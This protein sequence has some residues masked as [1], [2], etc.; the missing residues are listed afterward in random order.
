MCSNKNNPWNGRLN[1]K[2]SLFGDFRSPTKP[3][4]IVGINSRVVHIPIFQNPYEQGY[5]SHLKSIEPTRCTFI[6]AFSMIF[7]CIFPYYLFYNI[8]W[9]NTM[10]CPWKLPGGPKCCA[11][12]INGTSVSKTKICTWPF[13]DNFRKQIHK[14]LST[15]PPIIMEVENGYIWKVTTIGG[16]PFWLPWLWEEV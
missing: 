8:R 10:D 16:T 1:F 2:D 5:Y 13:R 15:L 11:P 6:T 14:F 4:N 9:S 3:S 12:R 7:L